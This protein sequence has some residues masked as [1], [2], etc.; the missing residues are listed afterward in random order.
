MP[1]YD[2]ECKTCNKLVEQTENIPMPCSTCGIV[3]T[4]IWTAPSIQFK[5]TGW[6]GSYGG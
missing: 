2:F 3:M 4:R 5:G 1:V 6:G